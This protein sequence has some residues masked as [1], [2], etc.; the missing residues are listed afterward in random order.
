MEFIVHISGDLLLFYFFF[1][2]SVGVAF[3][4]VEP[5]GSNPHFEAPNH[6]KGQIRILKLQIMYEGSNPHFEAPNHVRRLKSAF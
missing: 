6:V 4:F 3:F 1:T 2:F 5:E